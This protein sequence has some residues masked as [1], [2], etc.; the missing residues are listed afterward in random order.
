MPADKSRLRVL[1][2]IA[3]MNLGGPAHH[4]TLL[5]GRLDPRRYETLLV[6]GAVG[7]GEEEH[8]TEDL[9]LL[10]LDQLGPEIRPVRDLRALVSLV[11]A[12]RAYRPAIVHTHTAKAGMLGRLAAMA[13]RPRPI[14]VHTYHGHV[15]RGYF[16]PLKSGAFTWLERLL[17]RR[18]DRLIGVSRATVEELVELR[19]APRS[20]FEVVPLGLD[21][22]RFLDLDP[23]PDPR[24]RRELGVGEEE[25]LF[26]FTGRLAQIKRADVMLGALARARAAGAPV[27]V[28][29]VGDGVDR[30][31][32]E[33]RAAEL[34]CAEAVDFLGYRTDLP[35]VLAAADAALL[36]SDN[37]GTPVA[38]I[39]AAAAARPAV[40]TDVGGVSDIVLA[41]TGLLAQAG[42]EDEI[43]AAMA[44]LAA[45]RDRRRQ[46]GARA[47]EHVRERY[48][49]QR[50]LGDLD[51][52][53]SQLLETRE[54]G[55]LDA[56]TV[57]G[58]G[59]EW[60]SFDQSALPEAE[61]EKRFDEYFRLFPW[62]AL[63]PQAV[64]FDLGCGSGRWAR[65]VAPRVGRLECVDA[66]PA[67]V[68]VAERTLRGHDNCGFHVASVDAMPL[69]P[70]SMDFGYSLGVLHHVPDTAAGI[71]ACV[72][73][74]KP[75][76]PLLLYLYYALDQRPAWFRGLWRAADL[77][78]RAISRL[79]HRAKLAVTATIAALVY[80]PLARLALLLERTGRDVD[81]LPLSTYRR[82]GFYTMRTDALDRFGT[83]L[84][85]RFSAEEVRA[86]MEAAGL[87]RVEISSE[88]P[89]WCALGYK[90]A[91]DA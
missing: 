74:L 25:V 20:K 48:A 88:P 42:E 14:V 43:A 4:V 33:A 91:V 5:S 64:G 47:R 24:A 11:R 46:M 27:R 57:A 19:V 50:L 60:T 90:R 15:L 31:R 45:D 78:R 23:E 77:G 30:A 55:N 52:L 72:A 89:Y 7:P 69:P 66:S 3:R 71:R 13:V 54:R 67:A 56:A 81:A 6:T 49:A 21:L 61:L 18:S 28:A 68:A 36:T 17:A 73:P 76:A 12:I 10:R 32:L 87:E 38:L 26:T 44:A 75:G 65:S 1:R 39:E 8:A 85:R 83:R 86:M 82:A 37:E 59:R 34:G 70:G 63:P 22:D 16:G 79:P 84:E 53:Y 29:V 9:S 40:A 35:R 80:L 2:V 58:F 62:E 51:E 41:G